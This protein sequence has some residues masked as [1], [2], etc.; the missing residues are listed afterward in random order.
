MTSLNGC[1]ERSTNTLSP[2]LSGTEL[3]KFNVEAWVRG[4]TLIGLQNINYIDSQVAT[5]R[6]HV[7]TTCLV[8]V[9]RTY[10]VH[11][12]TNLSD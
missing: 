3:A 10:I 7:S 1:I 6:S 11:K 8:N 9:I 5:H 4:Y 2:S 12:P